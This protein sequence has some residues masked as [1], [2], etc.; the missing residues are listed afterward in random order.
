MHVGPLTDLSSI[1][2]LLEA[3]SQPVVCF[4]IGRSGRT[5]LKL[6]VGPAPGGRCVP[7][8]AHL[9]HTNY[10]VNEAK[11]LLPLQTTPDERIS[12]SRFFMCSTSRVC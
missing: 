6:L 4:E 3:V 8:Y 2:T 11:V 7:L 10:Y 5:Q 9:Q 12:A 1:E